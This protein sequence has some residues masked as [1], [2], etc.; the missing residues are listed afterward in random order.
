M[1]DGT[2]FLL[3]RY[4]TSLNDINYRI[5]PK[6]TSKWKSGNWRPIPKTWRPDG[7]LTRG[8]GLFWTLSYRLQGL[9][10]KSKLQVTG[11]RNKEGLQSKWLAASL[12]RKRKKSI[13]RRIPIFILLTPYLVSKQCKTGVEHPEKRPILQSKR[14][15]LRVCALENSMLHIILGITKITGRRHVAIPSNFLNS[16]SVDTKAKSGH[17]LV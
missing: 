14:T 5:A 16:E 1:K 13:K 15:D 9:Q 8:L 2:Y 3:R 12:L 7:R 17:V 10:G 6:I 11:C 4:T